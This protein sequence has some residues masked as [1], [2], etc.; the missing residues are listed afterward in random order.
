MEYWST[1]K[2][3]EK[4]EDSRQKTVEQQRKGIMEEWEKEEDR[5]QNT[6]DRRQNKEEKKDVKKG[7]ILSSDSCLLYSSYMATFTGI[8]LR[9]RLSSC[10]DIS[11]SSPLLPALM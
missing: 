9:T 11:A 7:V 6:V 2:Q 10:G 3:Q 4:T 1:G 8:G 5:M